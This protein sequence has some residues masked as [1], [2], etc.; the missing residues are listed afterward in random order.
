MQEDLGKNKYKR[1]PLRLANFISLF[2]GFFWLIAGFLGALILK[3]TWLGLI[4]SIM[5]GGVILLGLLISRKWQLLAAIFEL[6]AAAGYLILL[7]SNW[8]NLEIYGFLIVVFI[9]IVPLILASGLLI[10]DFL[11][12]KKFIPL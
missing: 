10:L 2:F 9:F 7:M 5:P 11:N 6:A 12:R 4:F 8:S 1:W 3:Q